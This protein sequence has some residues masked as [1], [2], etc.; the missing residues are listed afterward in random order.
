F[1]T[2]GLAATILLL[3]YGAGPH[4]AKASSHSEAPL[5]S[6]DPRADNTD[7]YAFVSP[8]D[9]SKVTIVA[10]YIP[11]EAPASGP[12]FY[13]FDDSALYQIGID[14]N[15]DGN[16]DTAYQ[17]RFSTTTR[18]GNTFLYNTGPISSLSD[19]TWNRPQTYTVTQVQLNKNGKPKDAVVLGSNIPTPPDNIGPRSTPNYAALATAAVKNLPGGIKVFA[20]Q[21]D[22]PF[23]VDLGSI[24]DLAGLRPFNPFHLIPL[25]AAAGVDGLQNYNTHSIVLR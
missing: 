4:A 23:Y 10:N 2:A 21:R 18:N 8:E 24:F 5:I 13:S 15:G 14:R 6:Q 22:D 11:L 17:F 16:A 12:N 25:P 19:P 1:L 20:G 3:V 9:T 7:L